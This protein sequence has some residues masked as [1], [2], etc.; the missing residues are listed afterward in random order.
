MFITALKMQL[1]SILR[2]HKLLSTPSAEKELDDFAALV[3]ESLKE[4]TEQVPAKDKDFIQ[5]S[6]R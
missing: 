6:I 4:K 2:I 1:K 5:R 3:E